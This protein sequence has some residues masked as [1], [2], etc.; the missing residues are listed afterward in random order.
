MF[1]RPAATSH[2]QGAADL[3]AGGLKDCPTP[4]TR[5][6]TR[7]EGASSRGLRPPH[8]G[9]YD[10]GGVTFR[11][12]F[13][14]ERVSV[15]GP[16]G[17]ADLALG[18][19][20]SA[21]GLRHG[22]SGSLYGAPLHLVRPRYGLQKASRVI[23]ITIGSGPGRSGR[24]LTHSLT[25][26]CVELDGLETPLLEARRGRLTL[27]A[28]LPEELIALGVLVHESTLPSTSLLRSFAPLSGLAG[29][30]LWT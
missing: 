29:R 8:V 15:T 5:T 21:V 18:R 22:A 4:L 6:S 14:I 9:T 10:A 27:A 19:A 7:V 17:S 20:L 11:A 23:H 25:E 16:S 28:G 13:D 3:V 24:I 1:R 26:Y 2:L 12:R 30:P